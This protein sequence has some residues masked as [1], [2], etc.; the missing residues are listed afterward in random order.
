MSKERVDES[1]EAARLRAVHRY[2]ILDS[3][4]DGAFDRV[5]RLAANLLNVPIALVTIVD[6]DRIWFKARHGL[7]VQEIG[8]DPG[9]CASAILQDEAWIVEN[10]T[11]D[12]RVLANPLVAGEFGLQ[13]YAGAPLRT[14]DGHNLGTLCVIDR[15][16]RQMTA[17]EASILE[18][19][20]AVVIDELELRLEARR[21]DAA[22]RER[23]VLLDQRQQQAVEL[24][25]DV[26]QALVLAKMA[27]D[28]GQ[29]DAVEGHLEHALASSKRI[30]ARMAQGASSLRRAQPGGGAAG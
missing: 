25:D 19:L 13:F 27:L 18:D 5:V 24:N 16:P 26:V 10:A 1:A 6:H 7:D 8:R 11:R 23:M 17:R 29:S 4:P 22:T 21:A 3:P 28:A 30:L 12:P 9:L 20:A 2:D 14:H 15:E